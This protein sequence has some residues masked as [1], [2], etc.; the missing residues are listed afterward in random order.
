M[1]RIPVTVLTGFLGSGK[2]TLLNRILTETHGLRIAVIENEFGEIGIDQDLVI[3]AEEEIFEMNNGCICCTVRGDLIRILG[4]LARRRDKFDRIVLETTGL[5]DP[6]PVAQTFFVDDDIKDDFYL[7]GIITLVDCR[8]LEQHLEENA[9]AL[10]QVAFADLIVLNKTDLVTD[11][12]SLALIKRVQDINKMAQILPASMA[13][14][15]I[16]KVLNVGGFD[17]ARALDINPAFLEPEYPFEWGGV[18]ALSAGVH[19]LQLDAGPDPEMSVMWWPTAGQAPVDLG[20]LAES[21]FRHFAEP[22]RTMIAGS[23]LAP[24]S[25]HYKLQLNGSANFEL[26][27]PQ[28]GLYALFTQHTPE[29]FNQRL[30]STDSDITAPE[31]EHYFNAEHTHDDEVSSVAFEFAGELD[32][33]KFNAWLSLLLQTEGANLYRMKGILAVAGDERRMNFQGV[34]ML[35][36]SQPGAPWGD[37]PRSNRLVFIGRNLN[38]DYLQGALQLCL[39]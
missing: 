14:V 16:H 32:P 35:F 29:E 27:V 4:N 21:V 13:D 11:V 33:E 15:P 17:L 19:C 30:V 9:E 3:N 34:H 12:E 20:D 37:E 38:R 28:D 7:D 23:R 2:T 6:G 10:A 8:H 31:A 36:D 26:S 22:P 18:Y 39:N 1:K 24:G 5:A 25:T